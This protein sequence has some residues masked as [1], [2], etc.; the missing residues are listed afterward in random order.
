MDHLRPLPGIYMWPRTVQHG[1][2]ASS[3]LIHPMTLQERPYSS[4]FVDREAKVQ[5]GKVPSPR[6]LS[7]SVAEAGFEPRALAPQRI[8][9]A[10]DSSP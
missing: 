3:H 5:K 2:D 1:L 4:P 6:C 7:S 10:T 9:Q 8:T